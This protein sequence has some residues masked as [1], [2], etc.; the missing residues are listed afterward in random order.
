MIL[1]HACFPFLQKWS[2]HLS[3][4][5]TISKWHTR[6]RKVD[7]M[8]AHGA[9]FPKGKLSVWRA[10]GNWN[11]CHIIVDYTPIFRLSNTNWKCVPVYWGQHVFYRNY[12]TYLYWACFNIGTYLCIAIS[13]YKYLTFKENAYI[14]LLNAY[15]CK[16]LIT[17]KKMKYLP[18]YPEKQV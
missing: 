10:G 16:G 3:S 11:R 14:H 1:G 7:R 2:R 13:K 4:H 18:I 6:A 5:Q 12:I 8:L 15:E 9:F 17:N